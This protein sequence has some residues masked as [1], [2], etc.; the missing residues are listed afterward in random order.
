MLNL[1]EKFLRGFLPESAYD[2]LFDYIGAMT[3][4][5][6]SDIPYKIIVPDD[7][8]ILFKEVKIG[9]TQES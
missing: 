3:E 5:R 9:I 7:S 2:F 4:E 8:D 6:H 1:R